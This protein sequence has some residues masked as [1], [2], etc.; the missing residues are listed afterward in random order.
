MPTVDFCLSLLIFLVYHYNTTPVQKALLLWKN[1]HLHG[2]QFKLLSSI[3]SYK[4]IM[5]MP[6]SDFL[7]KEILR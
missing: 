3:L 2:I 6:C 7:V 1:K 5:L 4:Y